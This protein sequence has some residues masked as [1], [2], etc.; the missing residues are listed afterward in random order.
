MRVPVAEVLVSD[1][2][3]RTTRVNAYVS[4]LGRTRRVVVYDTLKDKAGT[5]Q[6]LLVLAHELAHVQHRDVPWGTAGS[7][8]ASGLAVLAADVLL[9]PRLGDPLVAPALFL[10][11]TAGG[12]LAAPIANGISRWAEAR[13]DWTALEV[14]RDP[15]GAVEVER[16]LALDNLSDPSPNRLLVAW[17]A[18]HPPVM[19]RIAQARHWASRNAAVDGVDGVDEQSGPHRP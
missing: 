7:A 16:R 3:R 15:E 8:A 19:A 1:A 4:G 13:A 17:F 6:L 2:S 18:T 5:G 14:R 12:L 9:G 11:A 10:L